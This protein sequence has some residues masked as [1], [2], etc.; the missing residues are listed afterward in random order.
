[1]TTDAVWQP[2]RAELSRWHDCGRQPRFW[3]RDD[4]AVEPT[5]ALERLIHLSSDHE[6][7]VAVAVIPLRAKEALATRLAN[8][9][10]ITVAVHG[11]SH[12]NHAP[13]DEKK[14]ELGPHRPSQTVLS[15][16]RDG[17]IRMGGLFPERFAPVLVPPWNRIDPS[18]VPELPVL[19][20]KAIS[21]FGPAKQAHLAH[22]PVI[23]THVDPMDW[24]GTRGCRDHAALV[25]EIVMA[26]QLRFH[27]GDEPIGILAHHLVHDESAWLFLQGL[28]ETVAASPN[29]RWASLGELLG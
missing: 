3:L 19:G 5:P 15:E 7:S 10:R 27:G 18:L 20:Y 6:V 14:Q 11:W 16:L 2:L 4:D 25:S 17:I 29:A 9:E 1:M 22:L 8:E 28:F 23:N 24:H 13:S 12:Q 21:V 26:L